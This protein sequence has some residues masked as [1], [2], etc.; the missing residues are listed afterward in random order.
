MR[1]VEGRVLEKQVSLYGKTY[2]NL[3]VKKYI[4]HDKNRHSVFEFLCVCGSIKR[5][6]ISDVKKGNVGSCGCLIP[7]KYENYDKTLYIKWYQ[8]IDRCHNKRNKDYRY[9]G[10]RGIKVC[11]EWRDYNNYY[12]WAMKSGYQKGLTIDRINNNKGYNPD[13]CRWATMQQQSDNKRNTDKR[14][15]LIKAKGKVQTIEEWASELGIP[16]TTIYSRITKLG[17]SKERAVTT[18]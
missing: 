5:A 13:N 11:R 17:W 1:R 4:G 12:S 14:N 9:Y 7:R 8:M 18:K 16:R 15:R 2:G 3:T 6:R 10:A